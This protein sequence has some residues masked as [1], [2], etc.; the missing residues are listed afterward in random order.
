MTAAAKMT[1]STTYARSKSSGFGL[2]V[3]SMRLL[4]FTEGDCSTWRTMT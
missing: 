4:S 3:S 1:A 2:S